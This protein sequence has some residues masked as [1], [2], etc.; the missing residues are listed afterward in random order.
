MVKDA[1]SGPDHLST[2]RLS[3][4]PGHTAGEEHSCGELPS[5]VQAYLGVF[6]VWFQT[7][8]IKQVI[9]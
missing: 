3:D 2:E 1:D 7:T 5:S 9:Q 8:R 6:R 4:P